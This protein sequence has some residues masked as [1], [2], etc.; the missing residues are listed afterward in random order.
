MIEALEKEAD[1][2]LEEEIEKDGVGESPQK[3]SHGVVEENKSGFER[4]ETIET[5]DEALRH[6]DTTKFRLESQPSNS[7]SEMGSPGGNLN[8]DESSS[9]KKFSQRVN[10]LKA[11]QSY[12]EIEEIN[13]KESR[14]ILFSKRVI[15]KG[16]VVTLRLESSKVSNQKLRLFLSCYGTSKP[17]RIEIIELPSSLAEK[18][19][20]SVEDVIDII[21]VD[22]NPLKLSLRHQRPPYD[23]FSSYNDASIALDLSGNNT[24]G[25]VILRSESLRK[26]TSPED[27][28]SSPEEK[29]HQRLF[30][31]FSSSMLDSRTNNIDRDQTQ[32]LGL[33]KWKSK[34]EEQKRSAFGNKVFEASTGREQSSQ[35]RSTELARR[36]KKD[37]RTTLS[38]GDFSQR[39]EAEGSIMLRVAEGVFLFCRVAYKRGDSEVIV[40]YTTTGEESGFVEEIKIN[41]E[42][43]GLDSGEI[44]KDDLLEKV[45]NLLG[46]RLKVKRGELVYER[47]RLSRQGTIVIKD[48][49]KLSSHMSS[50]DE[51]EGKK[52][53]EIFL[54]MKK[55]EEVEENTRREEISPLQHS[56]RKSVQ[57]SSGKSLRSADNKID[58]R[59]TIDSA[60]KIGS[61]SKLEVDTKNSAEL[62]PTK[63]LSSG[64]SHIKDKPE[65]R[66]RLEDHIDS[67]TK[68]ASFGNQQDTSILSSNRSDRVTSSPNKISERLI[69]SNTRGGFI[70]TF[71]VLH[72]SEESCVIE[73]SVRRKHTEIKINILESSNHFVKSNNPVHTI[74]LPQ[75]KNDDCLGSPRNLGIK[76]QNNTK[77]TLSPKIPLS[78]GLKPPEP[79]RVEDSSPKV[80]N[81]LTLKTNPLVRIIGADTDEE[82][83]SSGV[84]S[85]AVNGSEHMSPQLDPFEKD[86]SSTSARARDLKNGFRNYAG[87][88]PKIVIHRE[89]ESGLTNDSKYFSKSLGN[90]DYKALKHKKVKTAAPKVYSMA[91]NDNDDDDD[92]NG[93]TSK[94]GKKEWGTD[95]EEPNK[96]ERR[97]SSR[98]TTMRP[99]IETQARI[100]QNE[101][102]R[103]ETE[104]FSKPSLGRLNGDEKKKTVK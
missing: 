53:R 82:M 68:D 35:E 85:F 77:D 86:D 20:P 26:Q 15:I 61:G 22:F 87:D 8:E 34:G 57:N 96:I 89:L 101:K 80:K 94:G 40:K 36:G 98:K 33:G 78:K 81:N 12:S 52:D 28:L 72:S 58:S 48:D 66:I 29:Q 97:S 92:E 69:E 83:G 51:I 88:I 100:E 24:E 46:R 60:A 44:E 18:K 5:Q 102:L 103:E 27:R 59:R 65:I 11:E 17:Q 55:I 3:S 47:N 13:G 49:D 10:L 62:K 64:S 30:R 63:Q 14:Y 84:W 99:I 45:S 37:S 75:S 25:P 43:L 42:E 7:K 91:F 93:N 6:D 90:L 54:T 56:V 76:K 41:L 74:Q 1:V 38:Q 104:G 19:N 16:Q 39:T 23:S 32:Y 9:H 21:N 31:G 67:A 71:G 70:E 73:R 95:R 4:L 2:F 50:R 79:R